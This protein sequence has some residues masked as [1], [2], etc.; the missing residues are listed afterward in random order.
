MF[1]PSALNVQ[2]RTVLTHWCQRG[3]V[4]VSLWGPVSV[5]WMVVPINASTS[6]YPKGEV[7]RGG[8]LNQG[9]FWSNV[10][11]NFDSRDFTFYHK[12]NTLFKKLLNI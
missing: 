11:Y 7:L 8:G 1:I 10:I 4:P 3:C 9:I 2:S 12:D 5:T 6:L